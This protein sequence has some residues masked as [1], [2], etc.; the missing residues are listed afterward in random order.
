[1]K[2]SFVKTMTA[3]VTASLV[4]GLAATASDVNIQV[5]RPGSSWKYTVTES[6]MDEYLRLD[7]K[8]STKVTLQG[9]YNYVSKPLVETDRSRENR[10][11][12]L[13][14]DLQTLD[15]L[16]QLDFNGDAAINLSMPMHMIRPMGSS[17]EFAPGDLRVFGKVYLNKNSRNMRFALIPEVFLPT[18][19]AK[20]HLSDSSVGFGGLLAAE[21]DMSSIAI[22]ANAGFRSASNAQ[23]RDI[24]Y[25]QRIPLSLGA[26]LPV[27]AKW[28]LTGEARRDIV[29]PF[30]K[31][32]NSSEI[33]GGARYEI[34]RNMV[35]SAGMGFG[36]LGGA[37]SVDYRL[38]LGLKIRFEGSE[39]RL[40]QIAVEDKITTV[41]AAPAPRVVFT[42]KEIKL[43]D[44][45]RF[46]E[47]SDILLPNSKKLLNEVA[48]VMFENDALFSKASI[49]GHTNYVGS[50][51]YNMDLSKRRTQA[52]RKY[53]IA[54]GIPAK[55]LGNAWY[56][57][58]RPKPESKN[59]TDAQRKI[60]NRRV[61]FKIEN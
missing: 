19:D 60:V 2:K 57:E 4:S 5:H 54:Q 39:E 9:N 41:A 3:T 31:F 38:L 46:L 53:L 14:Q 24:D 35:A 49:E 36:S 17:S 22:A 51:A 7:Q 29:I 50:D 43:A 25:R 1:M 16:A 12:T 34:E 21:I 6:A 45:V 27:A 32:E 10:I 42:P 11:Y 15:L 18:G 33:Y 23:F 20:L 28:S 61:E 13:V 26:F 37:T 52:V 48:K 8:S 55:K 59:M 30:N 58:R 56:G 40:P 44:E 47:G